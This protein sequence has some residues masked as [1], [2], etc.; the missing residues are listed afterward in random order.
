MKSLLITLALTMV[1]LPSCGS[2]PVDT[3]VP[4]QPTEDQKKYW[5]NGEA[6]L[7]S[8]K[9]TQA[10]YGEL[11]EGTAVMIFVTE[12]FSTTKFT[13]TDKEGKD[14]TSVL[15]LNFTKNFTTGIYPYSILTSS[16]VP[17]NGEERALKISSSIQEW[18]G[19]VYMELIRKKFFNVNIQS[20]FE[21]ETQEDLELPIAYLEDEL[22]SLIRLNPLALPVGNPQV[23]P[24][25]SYLR[26]MHVEPKAYECEMKITETEVENSTLWMYYK[27]LD[28]SLSITYQTEFPHQ[29]IRWQETYLD[30]FGA[31]K[32]KLTTVGERIT[33]I[34]SAYWTKNKN[35]DQY[36]RK[37]LG[38][39]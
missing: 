32:Q 33:T 34:R 15:K 18:C 21:D 2:A 37:E 31:N 28:R 8:F 3:P 19:H 24:S 30:G 25:F 4:Y 20:Y 5:Y 27:E 13:K 36:L 38:L 10:R 11:R 6:E 39:E 14:K 23:I 7:T 12:D 22:W 29:I 9:L 1:L 26:M 16:F 35:S 17:F